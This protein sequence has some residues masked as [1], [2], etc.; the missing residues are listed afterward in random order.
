MWF[1]SHCHLPLCDDEPSAVVDRAR[2]HGVEDILTVGID[3]ESSEACAD[4]ARS[5]GVWAAA[6]VHPNSAAAWDERAMARIDEL[7]QSDRVVAVGETGLDFYRDRTP[8]PAQENAFRAHIGAAK[9]HDKALVIHTRASV[10]AA[11][12]VLNHEGPP[13]RFVFHCW[14]GERDE[15]VRALG[16]GAYVS[17][18]GNVSFKNAPELRALAAAVPADRL[19][20][21]T[22]SPFLTPEPHRGTANEPGRVSLVG[23]AVADARGLRVEE[24]AAT[25]VANA[26]RLFAL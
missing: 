17:F 21:E 20:I 22:D 13:D 3:V 10:G 7:L 15:L 2:A 16:M 8:R 9:R 14:S 18:A 26:R 5:L 24:V 19:V 12:D 4:L 1:D 25:T 11:L 6:G 23:A